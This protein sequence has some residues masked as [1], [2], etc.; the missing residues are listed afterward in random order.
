MGNAADS[1]IADLSTRFTGLPVD[2]V[3]GEMERALRLM[4]EW[5]DTDRASILLPRARGGSS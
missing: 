3:D 2:E 5:L 4:V 1:L